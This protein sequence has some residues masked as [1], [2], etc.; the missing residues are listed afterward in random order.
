MF[1]PTRC[2]FVG[3]VQYGAVTSI[4]VCD[5]GCHG[6]PAVERS[7]R[8]VPITIAPGP[9]PRV[10][11][12]RVCGATTV[13]RVVC[14]FVGDDA[15]VSSKTIV[16]DARYARVIRA[17]SRGRVGR[18]RGDVEGERAVADRNVER[19]DA[20][21]GGAVAAGPARRRGDAVHADV[22]TVDARRVGPDDRHGRALRLAR[23]AQP[24]ASRARARRRPRRAAAAPAGAPP[25]EARR[26]ATALP[27]V[28]ARA[29]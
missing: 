7:Q 1:G 10:W 2:A 29:R 28:P 11:Y 9:P 16:R 4:G 21:R 6:A 19:P 15:S 14:A 12:E 8:R 25:P 20:G 22:A 26:R 27:S 3:R 18:S 23:D 13:N 24:R 5:V 17:R